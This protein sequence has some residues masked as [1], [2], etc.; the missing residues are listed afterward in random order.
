MNG[1]WDQTKEQ[2]ERDFKDKISV[3]DIDGAYPKIG[4]GSKI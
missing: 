2:K 1:D 3:K 4:K